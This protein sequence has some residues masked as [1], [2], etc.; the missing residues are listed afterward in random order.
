M[1]DQL[2]GNQ[3]N[4]DRL[5]QENEKANGRIDELKETIF[6]TSGKLD[7]FEAINMKI[8][9]G[10]AERKVL[11]DNIEYTE[12]RVYTRMDTINEEHRIQSKVFENLQ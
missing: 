4:I 6:N 12:K 3:D 11:A 7:V 2:V 8:A 1:Q 10:E 5:H 9:K